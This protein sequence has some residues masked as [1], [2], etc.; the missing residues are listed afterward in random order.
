MGTRKTATLY[1]DQLCWVPIYREGLRKT[2]IEACAIDGPI[3]TT[4]VPGCREFVKHGENGLLVEKENA[5]QLADAIFKLLTDPELR[6]N[7]GLKAREKAEKE[8][9]IE[10]VIDKTFEVYAKA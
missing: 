7:M 9:S 2:L 4:N 8:F 6:K 5:A 10:Q 1:N 3:V